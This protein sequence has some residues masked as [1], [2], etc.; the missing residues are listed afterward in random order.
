[1]AVYGL[2]YL[3]L[4]SLAVPTYDASGD[5]AGGGADLSSHGSLSDYA[6]DIIYVLVFVQL[7]TIISDY[8]WLVVLVVPL[9]AGYKLFAILFGVL[10]AS[11]SSAG[12]EATA[13]ERRKREKKERKMS[14]PKFMKAR[15]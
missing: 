15:R 12:M 9:F 8:F 3:W 13:E 2:L 10:G 1:M 5:L 4:S 6:F 11:S 14:R 7:T